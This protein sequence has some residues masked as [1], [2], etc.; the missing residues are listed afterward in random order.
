MLSF[1]VISLGEK[2]QGRYFYLHEANCKDKDSIEGSTAKTK[3][4]WPPSVGF[5]V[6]ACLS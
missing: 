4:G 6:G 2:P 5:L 3:D 1:G